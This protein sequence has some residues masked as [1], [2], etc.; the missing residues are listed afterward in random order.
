MNL[1]VL[2]DGF[3]EKMKPKRPEFVPWA[4]AVSYARCAMTPIFCLYIDKL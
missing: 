2:S 3:D 1:N 4:L